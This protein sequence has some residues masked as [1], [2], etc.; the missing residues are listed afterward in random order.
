M[1]VSYHK[2]T[3]SIGKAYGIF[4]YKYIKKLDVPCFFLYIMLYHKY[5]NA[6]K[7]SGKKIML[8]KNICKFPIA[9]V[10]NELSVSCFVFEANKET[11][12]TRVT[13]QGNKMVLIEQGN[14]T[15]LFD[16]TLCEFTTGTLLF[17]FDGETFA[18]QSGENVRY[19]YIDF[20]GARANELCRRFGIYPFARKAEN[21]H[22]LIPFWKESLSSANQNTIDIAAESVLLYTFSRLSADFTTQNGTLQKIVEYTEE[23]FRDP[24][25]SL[26]SIAKEVGY[27]A[28][29]LSHFF[30]EKMQISYSEYLRALRFKYAIS[31]F[32]H[33]IDSIKNV[34]YLSGFSDPLYFSTAFKKTIGVSPKEYVAKLNENSETP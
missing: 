24:E 9:N 27:N 15:F 20:H 33:G 11:M 4:P 19:L 1:F 23:Y 21:F 10:S 25:L 17:G 7:R 30:K 12:R 3:M 29:Y 5:I 32:E 14:G 28:K 26:T 2:Y 16:D 13:L 18:L 31:L 8:I 34:A 22:G 6:S